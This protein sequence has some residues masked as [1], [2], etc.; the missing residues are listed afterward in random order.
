[1]GLDIFDPELIP[2]LEVKVKIN[3]PDQQVVQDGS[4]GYIRSSNN[5]YF[6]NLSDVELNY[7][8]RDGQQEKLSTTAVSEVNDRVSNCHSPTTNTTN[9]GRLLSQSE[10][11]YFERQN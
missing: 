6:M 10:L 11:N 8:H 5:P 4:T 2:G 7:K 9:N 3:L 1:M